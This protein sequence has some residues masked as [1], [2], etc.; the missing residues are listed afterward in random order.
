M[1]YYYLNVICIYKSLVLQHLKAEAC[2]YR[3]SKNLFTS[4]TK[5]LEYYL[6]WCITFFQI[7]ESK[8]M[9]LKKLRLKILSNSS[10]T[11]NLQQLHHFLP[12]ILSF[13]TRILSTH[14]D[15]NGNFTKIYWTTIFGVKFL[16][17][18]FFIQLNS[19][20]EWHSSNT[21]CVSMNRGR[22]YIIMSFQ[23]ID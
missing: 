7:K 23:E 21:D 22:K 2:I 9:Q 19:R 4:I 15:K 11:N 5:L 13:L 18:Q 6:K 16:D 14:L 20:E 3:M 10:L 17:I 12:S 8:Y 1:F